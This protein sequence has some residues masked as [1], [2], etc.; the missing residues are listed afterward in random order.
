ML[1]DGLVETLAAMTKASEV[2]S[3]ERPDLG[4]LLGL[5]ERAYQLAVRVLASPD[6]AEDVVQGAYMKAL[7]HPPEPRSATEVRAWF[8]SIVVNTARQHMRGEG[9]RKR[10]EAAVSP[11]PEG[12]RDGGGDSHELVP[13]LNVALASLDEKHRLLLA[14]CYEQ[15]LS[16]SEAARVLDMPVSTAHKYVKTGLEKLRKTLARA[17]YAALPA[18]VLGGLKSTAPAVPASLAAGLE[19]LV[20]GGAMKTG[21][22]SVTAGASASAAAKGGIAMKVVAGIVAASA[23]AGAVA[24]STGMGG[25]ASPALGDGK[26]APVNPYKGMQDREEVFE[27]TTKP[28]V[29]KEGDKW[30]ITFASKGKCDATVAILDKDGKI[31]RHL[32]SGVLGANAPHPFQQNSLSQKLEWDGLADDFTK[33]PAGCKVKISLGLKAGFESNLVWDPYETHRAFEGEQKNKLL[34]AKGPGGLLYTWHVRTYSGGAQGRV[35]DKG[36]KYVRTFWPPPAK[37]MEKVLVSCGF[38]FATTTWGDKVPVC[39]W[40]GAFGG[41][42]TRQSARQDVR[43]QAPARG[44]GPEDGTGREGDEGHGRL[45]V[46]HPAREIPAAGVEAPQGDTAEQSDVY[47]RPHRRGSGSGTRVPRM[48][49]SRVGPVRRQDRQAG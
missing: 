31:V 1:K 49:G 5:G 3:R 9:R 26:P 43:G 4:I 40:N 22:V 24:V 42:L 19:K 33:A 28:T 20:A 27:F 45:A 13:A 7:R 25:G 38:K 17:G 35:F 34:T 14:L 47:I 18:A 29:K 48:P 37:D 41:A 46:G 11:R 16:Q 15:D 44:Y 36:G 23:L 2:P 32:A 30:V 8:F 12:A 39:G 21:G 10:R 6:A